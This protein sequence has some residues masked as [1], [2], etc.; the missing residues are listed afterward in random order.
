[1]SELALTLLR[2][3]FLAL[4]WIVILLVLNFMRRDLKSVRTGSAR[5]EAVRPATAEEPARKTKLGHV[6][7][8]DEVAQQSEY[9]LVDG[10]TIGRGAQCSIVLSD[11]Y[12]STKHATITFEDKGW[13]YTDL[14]S[15]NGSWVDRKRIDAPLRI[16]R[17]TTVRIGTTTL[18]FE[19]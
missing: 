12:A 19:K 18:R 3:G 17:G 13:F 7:V 9:Q 8:T 16:R 1:M 11:D 2:L 15:T 4:L 14:G 10:M 5:R 6:I